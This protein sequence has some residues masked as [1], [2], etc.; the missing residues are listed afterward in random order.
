MADKIVKAFE[1]LRNHYLQEPTHTLTQVQTS[2]SD[3]AVIKKKDAL[4]SVRERISHCNTIADFLPLSSVK[5]ISD[6]PRLFTLAIE[7]LLICCD[8]NEADVR[9]LAGECL[10]K[11]MKGFLHSNIGRIQVELY[12]EI[13]KNG[14][15]R[16]LRAAMQRFGDTCYLIHPNKCRPYVANLLPC[17]VKI[18]K[19]EDDAIQETLGVMMSKL[20]P[21]IGK[22]MNE[23]DVKILMKNFLPNIKSMS[24]SLRRTAVGVLDCLCENSR[25]PTH[26]YSWLISMLLG[27][28]TPLTSSMPS[29][30]I[31]GV[32]LCFRGILPNLSDSAQLKLNY[33]DPVIEKAKHAANFSKDRVLEKKQFLQI[34]EVTMFCTKHGDHNIVTAA[35]E[36]LNQILLCQAKFLTSILLSPTGIAATITG[37]LPDLLDESLSSSQM[38]DSGLS[39]DLYSLSSSTSDIFNSKKSDDDIAESSLEPSV[40]NLWEVPKIDYFSNIMITD[41]NDFVSTESISSYNLDVPNDSEGGLDL[42]RTYTQGS[43][44]NIESHTDGYVT[45]QSFGI[46]SQDDL[47]SCTFEDPR[48]KD[49]LNKDSFVALQS[50]F[51]FDPVSCTGVP[52]LH[53]VRVMCSF[54]LQ[55]KPGCVLPD[56]QTRV[57][58]KALALSCICSALK[59]FPEAF[60]AKAL[61]DDI[62]FSNGQLV[63]D[64]MLFSTH[65]DPHL[66]GLVAAIVSSFICCTVKQAGGEFTNWIDKVTTFYETDLLDLKQVINVLLV[67]LNDESATAV[68][69]CCQ[70]I[71]QCIHAILESTCNLLGYELVWKLLDHSSSTYWLVKV[72]IMEIFQVLNYP[73]LHILQNSWVHL[74]SIPRINVKHASIQDQVID[75]LLKLLGDEDPRVRSKAASA[76]V[77]VVPKLYCPNEIN[78]CCLPSLSV[79][80]LNNKNSIHTNLTYL[81]RKLML[82]QKKFSLKYVQLGCLEC[83]Y[84]LSISYPVSL[85]PF[86]WE[87]L[88]GYSVK[89]SQSSNNFRKK[90]DFSE[91]QKSS[92]GLL[93]FTLDQLSSSWIGLDL[94]AHEQALKLSVHLLCGASK[95]Y[96]NDKAQLSKE[97]NQSNLLDTAVGENMWSSL[98]NAEL[99][100]CAQKLFLHLLK[101][102]S[103]LLHVIEQINPLILKNKDKVPDSVSSPQQPLTTGVTPTSNSPRKFSIVKS[104]TKKQEAESEKLKASE[105]DPNLPNLKDPN[106]PNLNHDSK[107]TSPYTHVFDKNEKLGFFQSSPHFMNIY[108]MLKGVFKNYQVSPVSSSLDKFTSFVKSVLET[109]SM[110][111]ELATFVELGPYVEEILEYIKTTVLVDEEASFLALQQLLKGLFGTNAANQPETF[112]LPESTQQLVKYHGD[113]TYFYEENNFSNSLEYETEDVFESCFLV[114]Y[115]HVYESL[116][117]VPQVVEN[118]SRAVSFL[119]SFKNPFTANRPLDKVSKEKMSS[120]QS[121]IRMF[122]PLV[123]RALKSYTTTSSTSLQC[124]TIHLI[125]QLIRLRVNYSLLDSDQVFIGYVLKQFELVEQG[126]IRNPELFIPTVFQFLVLLSYECFQPKFTQAKAIIGMPRIMRLCDSVMACGQPV[127]LYAIPALKP[128]VQDLFGSSSQVRSDSGKDL[129]IQR[130]VVVSML[131]RVIHYPQV[132]TMLRHVLINSK[133][134]D[135]RWKRLSRQII[136]T[137]LPSLAKLELTVDTLSDLYLLFDLFDSVAPLALRP[138]DIILKSMFTLT[139]PTTCQEEI[140]MIA[141][142]ISLLRTLIMQNSEEI[143]LSHIP[144]FDTSQTLFSGVLDQEK[145]AGSSIDSDTAAT[146]YLAAFLLNILSMAINNVCQRYGEVTIYNTHVSLLVQTLRVF[147]SLLTYIG[148]SGSFKKLTSVLLSLLVLSKTPNTSSLHIQLT[149]K[150]SGI[151]SLEP[152]L[153]LLWVYFIHSLGLMNFDFWMQCMNH[154][155]E[156]HYCTWKFDLIDQATFLLHCDLMTAKL[157]EMKVVQFSSVNTF[158]TNNASNLLLNLRERPVKQL[159]DFILRNTALSQ[160]L[161]SMLSDAVST[162]MEKHLIMKSLLV[163]L[164][165]V[166]LGLS[167]NVIYFLLSLLPSIKIY[168]LARKAETLACRRMEYLQSLDDQD[169]KLPI[170]NLE[171]FSDVAIHNKRYPRLCSLIKRVTKQKVSEKIV[172][173]PLDLVAVDL[174]KFSIDENWMVDFVQKLCFCDPGNEQEAVCSI[175]LLSSL[176]NQVANGILENQKFSVVLLETLL[177]ETSFRDVRKSKKSDLELSY[178]YEYS[179]ILP[180]EN[181]D[182][183]FTSAKTSL[184]KHIKCFLDDLRLFVEH[185]SFQ[186]V[187]YNVNFLK[188][189][190]SD[191]NLLTKYQYLVRCVLQILY[192]S[193]YF[194]QPSY[195]TKEDISKILE[196]VLVYPYVCMLQVETNKICVTSIQ[197]CFHSFGLV[198]NCQEFFEALSQ[199]VYALIISQ[200]ICRIHLLVKYL[201][202]RPG[203]DLVKLPEM[204]NGNLLPLNSA[205]YDAAKKVSEL[206][207]SIKEILLLE[208]S[209]LPSFFSKHLIVTITG[210]ARIPIVNSY[211]RIPPIV[212]K[213]GWKPS[214]EGDLKTELPPLPVEILKEKDVLKEFVFRVNYIGWSSRM[215]FEETWAAL[216]G[217]L[218]SPPMLENV[219]TEEDIEMAQASCLAVH[220]ITSLILDTTLAPVPGNSSISQYSVLHRLRDYPFLGSKPGIKLTTVLSEIELVTR[221]LS[222]DSYFV[223]QILY[224]VIP[225]LLSIRQRKQ[226]LYHGCMLI[227]KLFFS[228]LEFPLQH[229]GYKMGQISASAIRTRLITSDVVEDTDSDDSDSLIIRVKE[230]SVPDIHRKLDELDIRSCLQFLLELFEQ[231]L[232][233]YAVPKTPLMLKMEAM[234]SLCV[235][236][237]LLLE[238]SHFEWILGILM[239]FS[240]NHPSE[241]DIILEYLVPTVC[242]ALAVLKLEGNTA[243]R[244]VK[245]IELCLR[246]PHVPLQISCMVGSLY[247]LESQV[248]TTNVLLT[249]ILTDYITKKM[250]SLLEV[251]YVVNERFAMTFWSLC[252]FLIENCSSEISD[253]HFATLVFESA[254]GE[255]C[256][257]DDL[258]TPEVNCLLFR[259]LERLAVSFSLTNTESERLAK[260]SAQCIVNGTTGKCLPALSL[261]CAC[262]YTG[263]NA[264]YASVLTNID[265]GDASIE[266]RLIM[267]ERINVLLA[268]IRKGQI[269]EATLLANIL[270]RI[271][272]DFLPVQEVMNKLISEFL[273]SQQPRPELIAK[274]FYK[275]SDILQKEG[276]EVTVRDWVFLCIASFVQRTPLAMA[277]WSL[278]CFF[279]CASSNPWLKSLFP[280]VVLNKGRLEEADKEIFYI[281]AL[282]FYTAQK[283]DSAQRKQFFQFFNGKIDNPASPYVRLLACCT[284]VQALEKLKK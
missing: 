23:D 103:I 269:S 84:L 189:S 54:L 174:K 70:A 57:S 230:K 129:D 267:M 59:I 164:E 2:E 214:L 73:L 274:I 266:S 119:K 146:N 131:L 200:S 116:K 134:D 56:N 11:I 192:P 121:Y 40:N 85:H 92:L 96:L 55:G 16:S 265:V 205:L 241:D 72:E 227:G 278:T 150:L 190:L 107:V 36:T 208:K 196:L 176:K 67:I 145:I 264:E 46:D 244:I 279:I 137:L 95:R 49:L 78:I 77:N 247:I 199:Q 83:F 250:T 126:Q 161:L 202:L 48:Q 32:L 79:H 22:F 1:A 81:L 113:P 152:Q 44:V 43:M 132:L 237:D 153:F 68:K 260:L 75:V 133:A 109:F 53:C 19:R 204:M 156:K 31:L 99:T 212:W 108:V 219:S 270:P 226:Q 124:Q 171:K 253:S 209:T 112:K 105:K 215:Q 251:T 127:H 147:L 179:Q 223:K 243:E 268:R 193:C 168:G 284:E 87:M 211:A 173:H 58:V 65:D 89:E 248:Q 115:N 225:N 80:V 28:V 235:L 203:K 110:L 277:V 66:R 187:S 111:L 218:S 207:E 280:Y 38:G 170:E 261:L 228:N 217:V 97:H 61:P 74:K 64:I 27:M 188:N 37:Q 162:I 71:S 154:T 91:V 3:G 249:P 18:A 60:V 21:V 5:D 259:G 93:V 242:K 62:D 222:S 282:D 86:S 157:K 10:N 118:R 236:S 139:T 138:A 263:K 120:I 17:I 125:D 4:L 15:S 52:A 240:Q 210:L 101:L 239:E 104:A 281:A 142:V 12:K 143:I 25:K 35:L 254:S 90:L 256:K 13:K 178:S 39:N 231:W 160:C 76:L 233:P 159:I 262:M 135:E 238:M 130:E 20:C 166:E 158:L 201:I 197:Q 163:L 9:L 63:R 224:P 6:F 185:D 82:H 165:H 234:K 45:D 7:L 194:N 149:M 148:K 128:I 177:R 140:R 41:K 246:S 191:K 29:N 276:N 14:S 106:F 206:V 181:Q 122:E 232:S 47:S 151:K 144:S 180:P 42:P 24:A 229:H 100:S 272:L 275:V 257:V 136:D 123:I 271:L 172:S 33:T 98:G 184:I 198:L 245:L 273:S 155:K 258:N 26:F 34:Y 30:T 117:R 252:F 216:L 88:P 186:Y 213:F 167:A 114:P 8:D 169:Y 182:Y 283:L 195:L 94:V 255:L 141:A 102:F 183:L 69:Q 51:N 175:Y 221:Y 50:L 220:C